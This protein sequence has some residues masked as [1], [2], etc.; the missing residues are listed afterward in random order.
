MENRIMYRNRSVVVSKP[1]KNIC[2]ACKRKV[3]DGIKRTNRHHWKYAY[4]YKTVKANPELALDNTVEYCF[5]CHQIADAIKALTDVKDAS[6]I[7]KV[8]ET[9]PAN[10]QSSFRVIAQMAIFQKTYEILGLLV[11]QEEK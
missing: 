8:L 3:G 2:D 1:R 6:S 7:I 4:T 9:A 11:E 5:H 10:V